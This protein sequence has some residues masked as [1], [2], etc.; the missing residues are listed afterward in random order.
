VVK[1]EGQLK[2]GATLIIAAARSGGR[3]FGFASDPLVVVGGCIMMRRSVTW[4][5]ARAAWP[6]RNP[7]RCGQFQRET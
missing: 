2:P 6:T 5:P 3:E 1:A 4:T 7:K